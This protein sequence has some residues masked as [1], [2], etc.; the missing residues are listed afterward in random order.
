MSGSIVHRL[1][2][3]EHDEIHEQSEL[4]T[5][6]QRTPGNDMSITPITEDRTGN[7]VRM[8]RSNRYKSNKRTPLNDITITP[9]TNDTIGTD[10][11]IDRCNKYKSNKRTPFNID[12]ITPTTN[13]TIGAQVVIDRSNESTVT[14]LT[15]NVSTS[16]MECRNLNKDFNEACTEE[17]TTITESIG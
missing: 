7:E 10:V 2:V 14:T 5:T 1:A 6:N 15:H 12:S 9:T 4:Y 8:D 3:D 17:D 13:D 11:R 16:I